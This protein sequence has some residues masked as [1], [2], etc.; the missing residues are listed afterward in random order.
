M[1]FGWTSPYLPLLE[2]GNY[3]FTVTREESSWITVAL[4]LG[5]MIGLILCFSSGD[6]FGRKLMLHISAVPYILSWLMVGSANSALEIIFARLLAGLADGFTFVTVPHYVAEIS[7]ADIRG[8]LLHISPVS[9]ALGILL[10]ATLGSLVSLP[11]TAYISATVPLILLL[12]FHWMPESPYHSIAV[13]NAPKAMED[14]RILKGT[15]DVEEDMERISRAVLEASL[16]EKTIHNLLMVKT[17][18]KAII[19]MLGRLFFFIVV[20]L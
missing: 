6:Q 17:N 10:V 2:S 15:E 13:G 5:E 7:S 9:Q 20:Y 18:R 1:H 14:L 3:S 19:L 11:I 12:T 16:K 8:G 4:P